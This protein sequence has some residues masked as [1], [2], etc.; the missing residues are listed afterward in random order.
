MKT[1]L[2]SLNNYGFRKNEALLYN[3]LLIHQDTPAYAISQ[4]T[5]IPRTTVY[6]T[7]ESMKK[8]GF[9]SSWIKNGVKHFSVES[10]ENLHRYLKDK[11]RSIEHIMPE[12]LNLFNLRTL[13]PSAKMY[14]GKEG[15]KQVFEQ[16]LE[17]IKKQRLKRIHVFSDSLI[18]EQIPEYYREW[19]E[20][21][22]KIG[23]F[24]QLIVPYG[25]STN[26]DFK[27]YDS[28]ETRMMP[29][30]FPFEGGGVDIIGT[31]VVFFSFR[32][33][34]IYAITVDAPI[35]ADMMTKFFMYIWSTLERTE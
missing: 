35:I 6:K 18:T 15:V 22:N 25:T 14:E 12:M 3:H 9:V 27:S 28:R 30:S 19:R 11:E 7:L 16:I 2:E 17:V 20:R 8:Q 32:D 24:T 29:E 34:Q 26:E 21:K 4:T 33:N 5:G 13:P 1:I 10:P 31:F 23:T